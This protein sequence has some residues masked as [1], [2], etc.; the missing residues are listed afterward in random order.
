MYIAVVDGL[1]ENSN[2][3]CK[4][5]AGLLGHSLKKGG[6]YT[7]TKALRRDSNGKCIE[8]IEGHYL[9]VVVEVYALVREVARGSVVLA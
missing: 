6:M 9:E 5:I 2:I 3:A 8:R 1:V 7:S 4:T